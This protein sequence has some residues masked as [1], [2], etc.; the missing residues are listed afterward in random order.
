MHW[1]KNRW[2]RLPYL[3]FLYG[4][5]LYG[6]ILTATYLA[7]K[8]KVTN[9]SGM[10]DENNRY[11]SEMSGKYNQSFKV[12][13]SSVN[14]E[15]YEVLK[16][17]YLMNNYYPVNA[18]YI[19][20]TW[21]NHRDDTLC[22][23]MVDAVNLRLFKKNLA[24]KQAFDQLK[25][26]IVTEGS[27]NG[28]SVFDWMNVSEWKDFKV[29]AVK[30]KA[31]IDSAARI[32]GV[33]SRMIVCCLVGEQ[34]R[35]FNSLREAYKSYISPAKVLVLENHLSY[36]VTGIK[37][38]TAKKIE[39][40]LKDRN[41]PYYLGKNYEKVLD[42]NPNSKYSIPGNN[43]IQRLV[44]GKN[45]YY[46]YLYAALFLK[47]IHKQW[48]RAGFPIDKRPEILASLFNLGFARSKPKPNPAVGGS[49]FRV[50]NTNY[51]FGAL[52]FEFYYS[53]ELEKEFPFTKKPFIDN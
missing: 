5:A 28:L 9:E 48:A 49:S 19:L 21:I 33:E 12:D 43:I 42:H 29:A 25:K 37:V 32:A 45:H 11:F 38:E 16:L 35:L 41:S 7:V 30:D 31:Y 17:V 2:I 27:T 51:T 8:F 26:T 52:A 13:T 40:Y 20:N 50:T 10:V 46:S 36:G 22:L 6:I 39:A 1:I 14:K 23:K 15:R 3:T 44:Q 47:E 53:G 34:I 4:F 18:S 24:Y